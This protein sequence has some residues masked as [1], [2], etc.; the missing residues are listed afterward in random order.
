MKGISRRHLS[1]RLQGDELTVSDLG[2][3]NGTFLDGQRM[4]PG[5]PYDLRNGAQIEIARDVS[6]SF[7][8][9]AELWRLLQDPSR[10]REL[11]KK[12]TAQPADE[13]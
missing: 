1:I 13:W 9:S 12:K 11:L 5:Q 7:W 10:L 2:S 3:K 8:D 6:G 4:I